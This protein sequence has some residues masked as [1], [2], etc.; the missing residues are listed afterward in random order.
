MIKHAFFTLLVLTG[1]PFVRADE[2]VLHEGKI[3]KGKIVNEDASEIMIRLANNMFLRVDKKKIK[4][5]VRDEKPPARATVTMQSVNASSTTAVSTASVPSPV[6]MTKPAAPAAPLIS[7]TGP[8]N[9]S[10]E[11]ATVRKEKGSGASVETKTVE[12]Y[13]V[14]GKTFA[15]VKH[16]IFNRDSGKG[17]LEKGGRMA[18]Q[19]KLALSWDGTVRADAG[20]TKWA[21]LVFAS[22]L[23]MTF[24]EW[25]A[26]SAVNESSVREW[27][28]FI[29]ELRAHDEGHVDIYRAELRALSETL[30][31]LEAASETDLREKS[32]T[33]V[34]EWRA[35]AEKRQDGYDR[36]TSAR[37]S[38][39]GKPLPPK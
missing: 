36:R 5:I 18:S 21:G 12:T 30:S 26:P 25:K 31:N 15:E 38:T 29:D 20:K 19:T 14:S 23:T 7:K 1:S 3:I 9:I 6:I 32:K 8:K 33:I 2:L 10:P 16:A 27:D 4:D 11:S 35:R 39:A 28:A 37:R 34:K 17:F 22:T 13:A 24:P